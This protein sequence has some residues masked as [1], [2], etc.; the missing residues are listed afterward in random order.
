M[1]LI[2]AAA[3]RPLQAAEVYT[4]LGASDALGIGAFPLKKGYVFRI[5]SSLKQCL[6]GVRLIDLGIPGGKVDD[7]KNIELPA[8]LL[9]GPDFA[10]VWAG[11]NDLVSGTD[12]AQFESDLSDILAGL[13]ADTSARV[14]VANLP[15][16]TM[17]PTF[18]ESPD[19]DVT[20]A[21]IAAYN[22]AIAR[23]ALQHN[24]QLVDLSGIPVSDADVSPIDGFH[25]S[26]RG[27]AL[28]AQQFLK[29]MRPQLCGKRGRRLK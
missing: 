6:N 23:Q 1:S 17:L 25:P 29:L 19:P 18:Q 20:A 26:N 9:S 3:A 12:P 11:P 13:Q 24:A 22:A 10:T 2:C 7:F 8:A 14:F 27:Y 21:R 15:D 28:I 5:R 4:A 16:M